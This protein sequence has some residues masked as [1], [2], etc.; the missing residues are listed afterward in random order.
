MFMLGLERE[1]TLPKQMLMK[2]YFQRLVHVHVIGFLIGPTPEKSVL[3]RKISS[4]SYS[5]HDR[6]SVAMN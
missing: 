6:I 4:I 5:C 2:T 3:H 1:S